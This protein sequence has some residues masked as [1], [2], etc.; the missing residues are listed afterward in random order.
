M[1]V[2]DNFVLAYAFSMTSKFSEINYFIIY[3]DFSTYLINSTIL[4]F[5]IISLHFYAYHGQL[6]R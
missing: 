6:A 1:H 4:Y 3:H 5:S 2:L